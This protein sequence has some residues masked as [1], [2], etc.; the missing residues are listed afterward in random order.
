[1]NQI[2]FS[3]RYPKLHDQKEAV[4][5]KV[6]GRERCNMTVKFIEY[7]TVYTEEYAIGMF[8]EPVLGHFPLPDG[9]YLVLVFLGC[10]LIPFTTVRRFTD[11]KYKY[12][13]EA[14][15]KVFDIIIKPEERKEV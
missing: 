8:A 3:H 14:I 7:D 11:E 1:M 4:L 6:F 5:I 10:D 2:K 12:Y 15:G 13:S 9:K